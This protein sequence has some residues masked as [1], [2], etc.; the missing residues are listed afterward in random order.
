MTEVR[1]SDQKEAAPVMSLSMSFL[2]YALLTVIT[3]SVLLI[4]PLNAV[5]R[6][7]QVGLPFPAV[8]TGFGIQNAA[9]ERYAP[10]TVFTHPGMMVL[11][12]AVIVWIVYSAGGY[13][14]AWAERHTPERIWSDLL[15]D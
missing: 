10:V 11:I 2:P 8:E 12:T 6:Q 15:V 13:Y 1:V 4:P 9:V 14:R 3:L 5:M 7:L